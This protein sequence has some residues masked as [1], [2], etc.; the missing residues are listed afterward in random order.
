MMAPYQAAIVHP[1][2]CW[3]TTWSEKTPHSAV[4]NDFFSATDLIR[5]QRAPTGPV[6]RAST[7]SQE[8]PTG[9]GPAW[10]WQKR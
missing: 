10:S 6:E 8:L 9:P 4:M 2:G 1:G 7:P 3:D 5:V